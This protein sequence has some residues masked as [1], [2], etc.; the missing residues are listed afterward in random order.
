MDVD[1]RERRPDGGGRR[2]HET[3]MMKT[4]A[5]LYQIREPEAPVQRDVFCLTGIQPHGPAEALRPLGP[6]WPEQIDWREIV[7]KI[8]A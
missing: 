3:A 6:P 1:A 2:G 8:G 5:E 7:R 4:P